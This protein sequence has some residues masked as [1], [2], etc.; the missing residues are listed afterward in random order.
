VPGRTG[1]VGLECLSGIPGSLGGALRMN[2]GAF[3][4]EISDH[5]VEIECL[6]GQ[7]WWVWSVFRG[8]RGPWGGL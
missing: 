3:G 5:L 4:A 1:L 2:A 7:G 6:D 8:S